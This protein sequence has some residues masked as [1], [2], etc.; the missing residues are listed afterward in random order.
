MKITDPAWALRE[1]VRVALMK[2]REKRGFPTQ[3]ISAEELTAMTETIRDELERTLTERARDGQ[4]D[5]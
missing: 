3:E 2:N 5:E 1:R 4:G